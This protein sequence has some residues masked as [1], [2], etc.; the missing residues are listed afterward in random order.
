MNSTSAYA[1]TYTNKQARNHRPCDLLDFLG[2]EYFPEF[3]SIINELLTDR[4]IFLIPSLY[5][6]RANI[7]AQDLVKDGGAVIHLD[8]FK[9]DTSRPS[10]VK[11]VRE[12]VEGVLNEV[13]RFPKETP[14]AI[15]S[16]MFNDAKDPN[17]LIM[18]LMMKLLPFAKLVFCLKT[19]DAESACLL[20]MI[21]KPKVSLEHLA[22]RLTHIVSNF[23][24]DESYIN[25]FH[26]VSQK[27]GKKSNLMDI[28]P[29]CFHY[30]SKDGSKEDSIDATV[31]A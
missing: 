15:Y 18:F 31:S 30:S 12:F 28:D 4:Q 25:E 6:C 26:R 1:V 27:Y 13:S 8:S 24:T 14:L 20:A 21:A 16:T 3:H 9:F 29:G 5:G 17:H 10:C 23:E 22:K 19:Y 11:S 2:N 7:L